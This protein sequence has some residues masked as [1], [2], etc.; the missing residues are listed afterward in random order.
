MNTSASKQPEQTLGL[1]KMYVVLCALFSVFIVICNLTYVK[2]VYLPALPFYTFEV[3]VGA[4]LYPIMFML[5]DLIAEFYDKK[6]ATFCVRLAIAMNIT[7]ALIVSGMDLLQATPWS[8]VDNAIFHQVFG[9]FGL[10]FFA[11]IIACYTAQ[12]VD[13]NLYLWIKKLTRG[14]GL[15]L[16]NNGSTAVSL[17]IDTCTAI[18]LLTLMGILPKEQ[19]WNII[20]N[21]YLYKL[22]ITICNT[23]TFYLL[24]AMVKKFISPQKQ[25]ISLITTELETA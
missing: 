21:S 9:H 2:F 11:N 8:K 13:I 3:S 25:E 1:E 19:M 20:M 12:L 24:V 6:R 16:R 17:L 5:T 23:P 10:A 15:W 4:M 18:I 14:R 7:A 22:F